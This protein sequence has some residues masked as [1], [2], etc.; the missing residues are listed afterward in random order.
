L[1]SIWWLGILG[2]TDGLWKFPILGN[3]D[4]LE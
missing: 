2:V 3:G 1:P 4:F